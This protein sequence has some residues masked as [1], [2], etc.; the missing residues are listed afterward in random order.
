MT[1]TEWQELLENGRNADKTKLDYMYFLKKNSPK[2]YHEM[3]I[4][5]SFTMGM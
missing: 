2:K 5:E 3:K 4:L 1:E